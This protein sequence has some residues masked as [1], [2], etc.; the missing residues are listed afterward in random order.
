MKPKNTLHLLVLILLFWAFLFGIYVRVIAVARADFP[1][2][3]GGMFYQMVEDLVHE[4]FRLPLTTTYNQLGIPYAYP[5]LMFYL[6][7]LLEKAG[8]NLIQVFRWLPLIFSIL[9]I[10]AF[11]WFAKLLAR[12]SILAAFAT[13]L[14]ALLPRSFEW[15]VMGGGLSRAPG[16][17]FYILFAASLLLVFRERRRQWIIPAILFGGLILLTHPERSL[18]AVVTGALI[19]LFFNRSRSGFFH[20]AI[21]SIGVLVISALW[22]APLIF[23][24][25]FDPLLQ[26]M[27]VG[28][29]RL[30]FWAP[31]LLLNFTDEAIPLV[32]IFSAV[33]F[34]YAI[35]RRDW[36]LPLW[37]LLTFLAD[38]RSA[39]HVIP[40]QASILAAM[41]VSRVLFPSLAGSSDVSWSE[42]IHRPLGRVVMGYLLILM[43]VNG[44]LGASKI[45]ENLV[46]A[47]GDR[48]ALEWVS[49]NTPPDSKYL[50]YSTNENPA[51]S[52]IL[53]WFPALGKRMSLSTYQGREWLTGGE[54]YAQYW[55]D[56]ETWQICLYRDETC[57]AELPARLAE[58]TTHIYFSLGENQHNNSLAQSLLHSNQYS[59]VYQTDSTWIFEK[60][61]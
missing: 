7:G 31:M 8:I 35:S 15:L 40:V 22:W 13:T 43:L 51:L 38:P 21:I 36:F 56:L 27:S 14:F 23:R 60:K 30:L 20:A 17:L 44:Q 26:V 2:N 24:L 18:H 32:A 39:V 50:V 10:P 46:L 48:T 1:V 12:D 34:I 16:A 3:D 19:W 57:L 59:I 61:Q 42:V 37:T 52:P 49:Q 55:E 58:S 29:N 53:E 54:N 25:G 9:T 47:A 45:A 4:N 5:P 6:A 41:T 11:W 28:G 33:G